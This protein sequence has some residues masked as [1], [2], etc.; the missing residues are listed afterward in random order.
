LT[1][2]FYIPYNT[3]VWSGCCGSVNRI[4]MYQ[5]SGFGSGWPD[6]RPFFT[7]RFQFQIRPKCWTGYRNRICYLL[8]S[9]KFK[10]KTQHACHWLI[11]TALEHE[12]GRLE[13]ISKH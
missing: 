8:T 9:L 4:D 13:I 3:E 11:I 7:T 10:Q 6:I 5:L 1:Y 12:S 2:S